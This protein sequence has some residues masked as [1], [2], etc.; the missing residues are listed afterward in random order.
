MRAEAERDYGD[1]VAARAA[2]LVRFAFLL[3]GDWHRAS[4][5]TTVDGR[6]AT[7]ISYAF[8]D[9]TYPYYGL[10]WQPVDGL[11]VGM[12]ASTKDGVAELWS[13]VDALR[14]DHAQHLVLPLRLTRLPAGAHLLD[15][16]AAIP[17]DQDYALA[18]VGVGDGHGN[19]ADLTFGQYVRPDTEAGQG[20][21]A[22]L[23]TPNRTVAGHPML[24]MSNMFVSD[25]YEGVPLALSVSGSY[26]EATATD[27]LTGL[28]LSPNHKDPSTWPSTPVE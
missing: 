2:V 13:D 23:P 10:L 12:F 15:C 7:L 27:I 14:L 25:D 5:P 22:S 6:P 26:N 17:V 19:R 9:G 11:W 21:P 3:C 24:W 4:A 18:M 16:V 20:R 28:V 8:P 1:Y